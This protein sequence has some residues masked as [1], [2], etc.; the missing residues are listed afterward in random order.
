[1]NLGVPATLVDGPGDLD[2]GALAGV[3]VIGLTAGASAPEH[4][5]QAVVR[6]L[7]EAGWREEPV[8]AL[9]ENVR[10]QLPPE[11]QAPRGG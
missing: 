10:F 1:M 7:A 9:Q 5:V 3:A 8:T 11:L 4:L 2:L 6:V